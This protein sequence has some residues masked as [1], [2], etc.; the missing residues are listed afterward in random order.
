MLVKKGD[1]VGQGQVI[2]KVGSTGSSTGAHLDFRIFVNGVN[3]D[4]VGQIGK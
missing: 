2:A 3:V 1:S 4:P